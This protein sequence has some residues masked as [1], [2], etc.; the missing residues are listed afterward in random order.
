[1]SC[2]CR[3]REFQLKMIKLEFHGQS[4]G[5]YLFVNFSTNKSVKEALESFLKL[6][7]EHERE[8]M[9]NLNNIENENSRLNVLPRAY[10]RAKLLRNHGNEH[11]FVSQLTFSHIRIR[12]IH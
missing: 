11:F 5:F 6:S 7:P 12:I 4:H 1:M 8:C 9:V 2:D 10:S 3:S